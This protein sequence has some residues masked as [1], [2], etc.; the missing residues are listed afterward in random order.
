MVIEVKKRMVIV[1]GVVAVAVIALS[2]GYFL[3]PK[4]M[5]EGRKTAETTEVSQRE[6]V[7]LVESEEEAKEAAEAYGIELVSYKEGVAV[8]TTDKTYEEIVK[9]GKEKKLIELSLN[10]TDRAF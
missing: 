5:L 8:F 3:R 2:A 1:I 6:L 9:I 7:G 4:E 10:I